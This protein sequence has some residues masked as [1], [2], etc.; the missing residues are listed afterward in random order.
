M[1]TSSAER[2]ATVA[3]LRP[4]QAALRDSTAALGSASR[5]NRFHRERAR[6]EVGFDQVRALAVIAS[7]AEQHV[8]GADEGGGENHGVVVRMPAEA[9]AP[10][11]VGPVLRGVGATAREERRGGE[12]GEGGE[13]G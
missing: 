10:Q 13:E 6:G 12:G 11:V 3:K 8:V 1:S 4:G 5:S 7:H 2:G 9:M